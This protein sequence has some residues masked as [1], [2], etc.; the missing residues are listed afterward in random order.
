MGI[1]FTGDCNNWYSSF[2]ALLLGHDRIPLDRNGE[3]GQQ[4]SRPIVVEESCQRPGEFRKGGQRSRVYHEAPTGFPWRW[5]TGLADCNWRVCMSFSS[6]LSVPSDPIYTHLGPWSRFAL[7]ELCNH[8]A[9]TKITTVSVYTFCVRE[10]TLI[11][12]MI[13]YR[14]T[15]NDFDRAQSVANQLNW[16]NASLLRLCHWATCWSTV[17]CWILPP[18]PA[19]GF[20]HLPFLVNEFHFLTFCCLY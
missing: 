12:F 5:V 13:L 4:W 9:S 17:W 14:S 18:L 11:R 16:I 20:C 6:L 1:A 15:A 19:I 3:S 7:S 2:L 8:L 10:H